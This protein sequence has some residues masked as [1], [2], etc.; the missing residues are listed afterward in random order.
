MPW[1]QESSKMDSHGIFTLAEA[2]GH[3]MSTDLVR[4]IADSFDK[5]RRIYG[6]GC[7]N[8]A[9]SRFLH[10][11]GFDVEAYE[12]T[13][14]IG[15]LAKFAPIQV[16]D[17]AVPLIL[18]PARVLCLEVGEHIPEQYESVILDTIS[19]ATETRAIISWAIVGQPGT[20]HVNCRNNDYIIDKMLSRGLALNDGLTD[21]GRK[22]YGSLIHF[23]NTLM[24]FDRM[25]QW[26]T[27]ISHT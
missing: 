7:G 12:G 4:W 22:H 10:D 8:G 23:S 26:P 14:D 20:G 21:E 16:H 13:P 1:E 24:V 6:L 19:D 11:A 15:N 2:R 18:E 3:E 27:T 5:T 17:L 9:Y 25:Q